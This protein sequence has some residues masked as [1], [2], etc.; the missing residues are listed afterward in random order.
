MKEA[1]LRYARDREI[2]FVFFVD[3]D[4]LILPA[5]G[6]MPVTGFVLSVM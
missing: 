2:D 3:A 6:N 1:A 5:N 4:N